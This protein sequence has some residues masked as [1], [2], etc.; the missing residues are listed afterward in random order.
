MIPPQTTLEV[1]ATVQKIN[2]L[3]HVTREISHVSVCAS[4]QYGAVVDPGH[5][6][7]GAAAQLM[8]LARSRAN[9]IKEE[10]R[11][12]CIIRIFT[13]RQAMKQ[14]NLFNV[15]KNCSVR[16]AGLDNAE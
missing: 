13:Q 4:L 12:F 15:R 8:A 9:N 7:G 11:G 10:N 1:Q 16:M 6:I 14:Y 3:L 5:L 2:C